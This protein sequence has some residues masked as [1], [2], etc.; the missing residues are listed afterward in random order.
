M[1]QQELVSEG[2]LAFQGGRWG[3]GGGPAPPSPPPPPYPLPP[4]PQ[5]DQG[6]GGGGLWTPPPPP[7]VRRQEC[8]LESQLQRGVRCEGSRN[9]RAVPETAT[10]SYTALY[11]LGVNLKPPEHDYY[12]MAKTSRTVTAH[13]P[14]TRTHPCNSNLASPVPPMSL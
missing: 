12:V 2:V 3:G 11:T 13:A 10:M 8:Y 7:A 4:T 6:G 9:Y 5:V 14:V 1:G